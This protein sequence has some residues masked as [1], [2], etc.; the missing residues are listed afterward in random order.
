MPQ[1]ALL[2]ALMRSSYHVASRSSVRNTSV[3]LLTRMPCQ[4]QVPL[5]RYSRTM[6]VMGQPPLFQPCRFSRACVELMWVKR[7]W[8]LLKEG[9]GGPEG[10]REMLGCPRRKEGVFHRSGKAFPGAP[11]TIAEVPQE[12]RGKRRKG[13]GPSSEGGVRWKEGKKR[14]PVDMVDQ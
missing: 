7:C 3:E 14:S 4:A 13:R 5:G 12:W 10:G 2:Q 6:A 9:S 1:P 11:G 8:S